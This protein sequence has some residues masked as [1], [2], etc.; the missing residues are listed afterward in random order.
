[1]CV[2]CALSVCCLC[3][4]C[5]LSVCCLCVVCVLSVRCLCVVCVLC[6]CCL[7]VV[8]VSFVCC[9]CVVCA[10]S[11]RCLCVVCVSCVWDEN[12]HLVMDFLAMNTRIASDPASSYVR[13]KTQ[14]M[15]RLPRRSYSHQWVLSCLSCASWLGPDP[16]PEPDQRP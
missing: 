5:A 14:L 11:V 13:N 9:L 6:V 2:V 1:L 15:S 16:E 7:C 3:V 8:C 10:L 12:L 4:V